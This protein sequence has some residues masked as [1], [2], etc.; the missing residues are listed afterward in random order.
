MLIVLAKIVDVLTVDAA[1]N[2]QGFLA[3]FDTF[4]R[5]LPAM[6]KILAHTEGH[7]MSN[8]LVGEHSNLF[9]NVNRHGL[10][11]LKTPNH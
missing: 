9:S 6:T 11:V 1:N 2:L 5:D 4:S 10:V 8:D 7:F 3:P